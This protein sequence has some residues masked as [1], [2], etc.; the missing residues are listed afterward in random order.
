M[1]WVT[2]LSC[3][4]GL[5]G[6]ASC[7]PE[8]DPGAIRIEILT[9]PL[10]N[11]LLDA[12]FLRLRVDADGHGEVWPIIAEQAIDVGFHVSADGELHQLFI[13]GLDADL[14]LMARGASPPVRFEPGTEIVMRVVARPIDGFSL[15]RA[16]LLEPRYEHCVARIPG[17]PIYVIG[18][19]GGSGPTAIVE[20]IEPWLTETEL[21][22]PL[23][24]ARRGPVALVGT[25]GA[26]LVIG[27]DVAD[28]AVLPAGGDAWRTEEL[29]LDPPYAL[30]HPAVVEV[31]PNAWILAGGEDADTGAT[32]RT[33]SVTWDGH[34]PQVAE[35]APLVVSRSAP[36]AVRLGERVLVLG[37]H[38]SLLGEWL[39][40]ELFE[41]PAMIDHAVV[42]V[43][44]GLVLV[45]NGAIHALDAS[46]AV[47][48]DGALDV[49]R[50]QFSADRLSD[51]RILVVGGHGPAA[52]STAELLDRTGGRWVSVRTLEL[53]VSRYAHQTSSLPGDALLAIGGLGLTGS[54]VLRG[55]VFVR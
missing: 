5:G 15:T 16:P 32:N 33:L 36:S 11:P 29:A 35:G 22:P 18:G 48:V 28:L 38:S 44:D 25:D 55:D 41:G 54:F 2:A 19:V 17:G 14:E 39:D 12:S 24:A 37:G 21:A 49:P 40:G 3:G 45:G 26:V 51:G 53:S 30:R 1:L 4:L 7:G 13:E 43:D 42:A 27:G 6:L 23:A 34:T 46:G 8:A 52:S 9:P 10:V 47:T 31:G 20:R 50:T